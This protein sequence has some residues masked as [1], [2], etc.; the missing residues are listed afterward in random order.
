MNLIY[1]N[2]WRLFTQSINR[3]SIFIFAHCSSRSHL[4]S[5]SHHPQEVP[6]IT[7]WTHLSHSTCFC[8]F[9]TDFLLSSLL[10]LW[11]SCGH[12]SPLTQLRRGNLSIRTCAVLQTWLFPIPAAE[13][14]HKSPVFYPHRPMEDYFNDNN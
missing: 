10:F 14:T 4:R 6:A 8:L 12:P 5:N 13:D 3:K 2:A 9:S 7:S 1:L 11:S